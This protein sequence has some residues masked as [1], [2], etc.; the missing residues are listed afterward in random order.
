M[1]RKA[2]VAPSILV[3]TL[4]DVERPNS[5]EVKMYA[6]SSLAVEGEDMPVT[7]VDRHV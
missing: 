5:R 3:K 1:Q 6:V 4:G 7:L 2:A